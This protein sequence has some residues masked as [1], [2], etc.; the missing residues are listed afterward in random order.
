M[1]AKKDETHKK[2]RHAGTHVDRNLARDR[3]LRE[4]WYAMI[5]TGITAAVAVVFYLNVPYVRAWLSTQDS[6]LLHPRVFVTTPTGG[7]IQ[8][9]QSAT[10]AGTNF[11]Q[12]S[13]EYIRD[14]ELLKRRFERGHFDMTTLPGMRESSVV[15]ALSANANTLQYDV[16]KSSDSPALVIT[17]RNPAAVR[18]VHDYLK[19]LDEHW[20]FQ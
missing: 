14:L 1:A 18:A 12:V 20:T 11:E 19:Y 6:T 9:R 7:S 15:R 4:L 3:S 13:D 17:A 5:A 2:T 16:V 10:P 8:Y